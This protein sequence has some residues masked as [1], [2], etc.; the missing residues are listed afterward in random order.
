MR[1][2]G[3]ELGNGRCSSA[4]PTV[5]VDA[6]EKELAFTLAAAVGT[7]K[8][9]GVAAVNR[10]RMGIGVGK[11]RAGGRQVR[12]ELLPLA[13]RFIALD[14]L[15]GWPIAAGIDRVQRQQCLVDMH[16]SASSH[17][18]ARTLRN[19][20]SSF[21]II[22]VMKKAASRVDVAPEIER[23]AGTDLDRKSVV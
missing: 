1:A 11:D 8:R 6:E 16:L 22:D 20:R 17:D 19:D 3:G 21:V 2:A 4:H 5:K 9:P 23:A 13:C 10:L 18:I 14:E 7:P 15:A 12:D